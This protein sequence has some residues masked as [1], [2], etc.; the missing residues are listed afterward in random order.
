MNQVTKGSRVAELL[1]A[2]PALLDIGFSEEDIAAKVFAGLGPEQF[3]LF[4]EST[5][6]DININKHITVPWL[7]DYGSRKTSMLSFIIATGAYTVGELVSRY[8][9]ADL[10]KAVTTILKNPERFAVKLSYGWAVAKLIGMNV[11]NWR[12]IGFA[13]MSAWARMAYYERSTSYCGMA[14]RGPALVDM[15]VDIASA[16]SDNQMG[17]A[18]Y[19]RVNIT[20]VKY[21]VEHYGITPRA[22][23]S[24]SYQPEVALWLTK[25]F[26]DA[27]Y[28]NE[29]Q[30][31][32][33]LSGP[34]AP[35]VTNLDEYKKWGR[36]CIEK[37]GI[38]SVS[39]II[40]DAS[41]KSDADV[42]S[43]F[44]GTEPAEDAV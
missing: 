24:L 9:K 29:L 37:Y 16:D 30:L 33:D 43:Y 25:R 36:M 42:M 15:L 34:V 40:G 18:A 41:R 17:Y 26:D 13:T 5:E 23:L 28:S 6:I 14:G 32:I 35:N 8:K 4:I 27:Y 31:T 21:L 3:R 19:A 1:T 20:E 10:E 38:A 22:T 12:V 39:F 2:M 11:D 7:V 44:Y